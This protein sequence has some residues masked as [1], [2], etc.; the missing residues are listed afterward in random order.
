MEDVQRG[1][2]CYLLNAYLPII[3]SSVTAFN[4]LLRMFIAFVCG[5]RLILNSCPASL[6]TLS[7]FCFHIIPLAA[8]LLV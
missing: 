7:L 1:I 8:C 2:S 6:L 3:L 4:A 5:F